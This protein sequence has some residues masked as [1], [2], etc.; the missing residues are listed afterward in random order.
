MRNG[1]MLRSAFSGIR[2]VRV[3]GTGMDDRPVQQ[4]VRD[5]ASS[6]HFGSDYVKW[7]S[8]DQFGVLRKSLARYFAAELARAGTLPP[9]A[10]VLE[11][12]FGK[13]SFLEFARRQGWAVSGTEVNPVLAELAARSGHDVQCTSDL[14]A[15]P[16]EHFDLVVAFDV[17]EHLT[18]E[19]IIELLC[20]VRRM[21]K[22]QGVFLARFPNGD[23]P[24]GL[25]NQNGDVTHITAIGS[26]KVRYLA[27]TADMR[28]IWIGGEAM[29]LFAVRG[30]HLVRRAFAIP[31]RALMNVFVNAVFFPRRKIDFCAANLTVVLGKGRDEPEASAK[32]A[33]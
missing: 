13:G 26:N 29:P 22:D 3:R 12:G 6:D 23:S 16:S 24:F 33:A 25:Y 31:V 7:K 8:W 20:Q 5:G 30:I 2:S 17:L 19:A 9:G 21:L 15:F 28:L 1:A 14:S 11:I 4:R 10:R 32:P 27:V 18:H